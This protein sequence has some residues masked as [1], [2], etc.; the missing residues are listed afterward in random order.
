MATASVFKALRDIRDRLTRLND[1]LIRQ[2][3]HEFRP[4][5]ASEIKDEWMSVNSV[6]L[7]CG[8]GFGWR[9]KKSPDSVCHYFSDANGV[10]SLINGESITIPDPEPEY[11]GEDGCL[12]CG[13]PN[14]RK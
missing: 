9:C 2:C 8:M 7:I 5:T 12:F 1:E 13:H 3:Q 10:V 11:Q 6:C 4:L 14:E